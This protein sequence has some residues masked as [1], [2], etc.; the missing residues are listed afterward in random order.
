MYAWV[1]ENSITMYEC[2]VSVL[3]GFLR[4]EGVMSGMA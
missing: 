3:L 2:L 4:G 1:V